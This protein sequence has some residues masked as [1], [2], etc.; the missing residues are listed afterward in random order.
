M[1]FRNLVQTRRSHRL[2][3]NKLID[4]DTVKLI[5]RAA[6]MSPTSKGRRSWQFI[7]VD[8]LT[9]LKKLSDCKA[10]GTDAL[11]TSPLA[12][13]VLVDK[14]NEC[15]IEDG[16]VAAISMQ[17]QAEELGIGSC[18]IQ[19]RGHY[20]SD[21]SSSEDVVR[22]ILEIPDSQSVLCIIAFGHALDSRKPQNEERLKWENVH[23]GKF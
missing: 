14:A 13:V 11:K 17:Y 18:W 3:S 9:D 5:L 20:L 1:D 16:S 8:E 22:G 2:F 19:I 7:V 10:M 23:I 15:W 6:L 12:V 21:G 4:A